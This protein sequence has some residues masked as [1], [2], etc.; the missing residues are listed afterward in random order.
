MN[1][2]QNAIKGNN[3]FQEGQIFSNL[4]P[5]CGDTKSTNH[6]DL[7]GYQALRASN[8]HDKNRKPLPL[9]DSFGRSL[10]VITLPGNIIIISDSNN[11]CLSRQV[12]TYVQQTLLS[13]NKA[14]AVISFKQFLALPLP[15]RSADNIS[16]IVDINV[17]QLDSAKFAHIASSFNNIFITKLWG[18]K[19]T[20][21]LNGLVNSTSKINEIFNSIG[22]S[23]GILRKYMTAHLA[24]NEFLAISGDK[25]RICVFNNNAITN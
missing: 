24:A 15:K 19:L 22:G 18:I 1:L 8:E 5:Q 12:K 16:Y 3:R 2:I 25:Q 7:V 11:D 6:N 9:F 13:Q 17:D 4:L 20:C 21:P 10:S 14:V 23:N